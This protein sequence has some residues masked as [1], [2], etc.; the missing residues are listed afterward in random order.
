MGAAASSIPD[1]LDRNALVSLCGARFSEDIY[2]KNK[3]ADGFVSKE[4]IITLSQQTQCFLSHDW[5]I[6]ALGRN[7]HERVAIV[8][9]G[10]KARGIVTWFDAEQMSGDIV[11]KMCQGIDNTGIVLVFV[12]SNYMSKVGGDNDNDNCKLE[13]NYARRRKVGKMI[14][15]VMEA[16]VRASGDWTGPVGMALGGKLYADL[17]EDAKFDAKLDALAAQVLK[18]CGSQSS[19]PLSVSVKSAPSIAQATHTDVRSAPMVTSSLP[20]SSGDTRIVQQILKFNST[21]TLVQGSNQLIFE[22]QLPLK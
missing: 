15:I 8:N 12:T 18:A 5:G 1:K 16:G 3:D 10:L 14:P 4:I 13:F 21:Y 7:N 11:D 9:E 20:I 22:V 2:L 6:D 19:V 17:S